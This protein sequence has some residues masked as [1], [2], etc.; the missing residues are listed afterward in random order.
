MSRDSLVYSWSGSRLECRGVIFTDFKKHKQSLE[1]LSFLTLTV[2]T[3]T[4]YDLFLNIFPNLRDLI[5]SL[6]YFAGKS[7]TNTN[8]FTIFK[9]IQIIS[10]H[11][12]WDQEKLF[13]EK[14]GDKNH[15][16][17]SL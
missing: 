11:A 13:D 14:S 2:G 3:L 12:Y 17:L 15:V 10:G 16:T 1:G 7:F 8:N 9:K 6:V 5:D 4:T